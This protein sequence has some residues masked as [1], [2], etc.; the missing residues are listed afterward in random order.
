MADIHIQVFVW[1][2]VFI[3]LEYMPKSEISWSYMIT[4]CLIF[5]ELPILNLYHQYMMVLI[6][7]QS[8]Q[9]VILWKKNCFLIIVILMGV[10]QHL[11]V[12]L[13]CISLMIS[14]VEDLFTCLLPILYILFEEV[15]IQA[16]L[17]LIF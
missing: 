16:A 9:Y 7:S 3:S 17:C 15:S 13:I 10:K 12:V 11:I 8:C 5:E 2:Y 1:A 6:S 4:L 14:D